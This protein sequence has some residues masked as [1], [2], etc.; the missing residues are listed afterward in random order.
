M[1]QSSWESDYA[2]TAYPQS[3]LVGCFCLEA[4]MTSFQEF[5]LVEGAKVVAYE[6]GAVCTPFLADYAKANAIK[7][8]AVS[9]ADV[10]QCGAGRTG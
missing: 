5:G 2:C 9:E 7:I 4:V 6:Q 10:S 8:L 1:T 3:T